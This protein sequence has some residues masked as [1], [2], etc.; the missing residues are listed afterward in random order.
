MKSFSQKRETLRH[1]VPGP[2]ATV[3]IISISD[4]VYRILEIK[5]IKIVNDFP[6]V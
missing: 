6:N 5:I 3:T 2:V 4:P 1:T